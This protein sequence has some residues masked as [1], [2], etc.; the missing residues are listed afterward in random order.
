MFAK[1]WRT[2]TKTVTKDLAKS[3]IDIQEDSCEGSRSLDPI[4]CRTL[5]TQL[6]NCLEKRHFLTSL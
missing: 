3:G 5:T 1:S 6:L 4:G 2:T